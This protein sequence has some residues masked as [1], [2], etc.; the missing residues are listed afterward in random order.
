MIDWLVRRF[1]RDADNV[2]DPAVRER[3]GLLASVV[4]ILCNVALC[5]GKGLVGLA[6]G[7]V[8][9]VADAANNLSDASSNVV[10]LLGFRLANRPPDDDHPYGHGRY[11]Y[12]AS[13]G[14]AI[15]VIIIGVNLMQDAIDQIR[16][17][18]V[19]E[20][21]VAAV[22]VLVVSML[23]KLWMMNLN[24]VLGRRI[25]SE[26]LRATAID[27]RND[28]LATGAVL[29]STVVTWLTGVQLDGWMGLAVGGLI[30]WSGV[31]LVRETVDTLL[32][33]APDQA[34]V[35]RV[36][37]RILSVPGILGMHDLMIHDY[38]PGRQF[39]SAHVEMS[40]DGSVAADHE[41]LDRIERDLWEQER[42]VITLHL[43]PFERKADDDL[44]L[45]K[46]FEENQNAPKPSGRDG[47]MSSYKAKQMIV[48]RRDLK[49]R[50]GKIA[51]QAGHACV[52]AI[53]MAL[54]REG[55]L[56]SVRV[57]PDDSW[58][59]LADD[60]AEPTPLTDWFG[61][62]VAKVC[63]YVDSE[64]ALLDLAER[65]RELGFICALVRDAGHTEFHG[66]PT[67]TC[68]AFEPLYPEQ[69]DPLTGDLPLF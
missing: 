25:S 22:V 28:V 58:V 57:T 47:R 65:G 37:T 41:V 31:T 38:G 2:D 4:C 44:A 23:V 68:L 53:L 69:I 12:L 1:V 42:L 6:I 19:L 30:V 36:R 20:Q 45:Q 3:Y 27:S 59:Y 43:D 26:T 8:A 56:E 63:V 50:K 9:I 55:R 15:I 46:R 64:E 14:V 39:A 10:S 52:E 33:H 16:Q 54:A 21:S 66:E 11:E 61:A 17:P 62:G 7:S 48:M 34:L 24:T 51:A 40:P 32:G 29:I 13:L 18:S 67:F 5:L 60:G 35:D 49:M